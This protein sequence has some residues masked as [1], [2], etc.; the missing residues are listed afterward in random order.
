[1]DNQNARETSLRSC[2][3]TE[4]LLSHSKSDQSLKTQRLDAP[5]SAAFIANN[6]D[7]LTQIL[8]NLPPKSLL[9]FQGV[10]KQWLSI[11]SSPAFRRFH[12]RRYPTTSTLAL[13]LFTKSNPDLS[14]LAFREEDVNSMTTIT[15]KLSYFLDGEILAL[16][17]CKGL[18]C[19]KFYSFYGAIE[20]IVYN[21]TTCQYRVI[22]Q[23]KPAKERYGF[24]IMNIAFNPLKSDHYK[25]VCVWEDLSE[26]QFHFLV[27]SSK[28]RA[29]RDNS[30]TVE[31]HG[32]P[33]Y[34]ERGVLWNG[35]LHWISEWWGT[36]CFD[37][38]NE[39]LR[40]EMPYLPTPTVHQ[41]VVYFFGESGDNL[42]Y[43]GLNEVRTM[44]F[45]VFALERDYSQWIVKY[46]VDL[47]PLTTMYPEMVAEMYDSSDVWRCPLDMPCFLVDEKEKKA[48]LVISGWGRVI[49]YD[50]DNGSV[51][52][53]VEVKPFELFYPRRNVLK[54]R[55]TEV[56]QHIETL[57]CV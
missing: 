47:A 7:L 15:S 5:S 4:P 28:T 36:L 16:H 8:L 34:F 52:D 46:I 44:L 14:F 13:I 1:M 12:W 27:Y 23:H 25:I 21:P 50:I 10:S 40:P 17:S 55:W 56:Y 43:I 9:R 32:H 42:Y 19:I 30:E 20:F 26:N 22:P 41:K 57:S 53:L 18:L 38:D 51:K 24:P 39:C 11:I 2:A 3:L 29:W 37:L 49:S 45:N 31:M 48:M 6:E 35:D 54:Y 33:F